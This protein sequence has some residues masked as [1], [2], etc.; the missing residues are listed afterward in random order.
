MMDLAMVT[1]ILNMG[2]PAVILVLYVLERRERRALQREYLDSLRHMSALPP[3]PE[4]EPHELKVS[5]NGKATEE[6]P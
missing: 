4:T 6:H 3:T 2:F 5:W 1:E